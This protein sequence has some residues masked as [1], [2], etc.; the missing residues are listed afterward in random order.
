MS[1]EPDDLGVDDPL[2]YPV[3]IMVGGP[4]NANPDHEWFE[5]Q[6]LKVVAPFDKADVVI[7]EGKAAGID[8]RAN[9]F[10]RNHDYA[11][12]RYPAEWDKYQIPGRKNPA[13]MIRNVTMLRVATHYAAFWDGVS[14]GTRGAIREAGRLK[15]KHVIIPLPESQLWRETDKRQK[16]SSST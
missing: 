1:S 6:M 8:E 2:V 9:Q 15:V 4:R 5:A 14:P 12:K 13:G 11:F 7:I 10:A 3:R 16:P